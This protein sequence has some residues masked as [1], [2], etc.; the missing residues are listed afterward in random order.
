MSRTKEKQAYIGIGFRSKKAKGPE[1]PKTGLEK[2]DKQRAKIRFR[3][4]KI[5]QSRCSLG[6]KSKKVQKNTKLIK[7]L[8]NEF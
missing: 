4:L 8:K 5:P 6:Q 1:E 3:D 2:I 7:A